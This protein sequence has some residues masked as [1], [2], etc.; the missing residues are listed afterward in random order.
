MSGYTRQQRIFIITWCLGVPLT[1]ASAIQWQAVS[2][3]LSG[4]AANGVHGTHPHAGHKR[5]C[6]VPGRFAMLIV[7]QALVIELEMRWSLEWNMVCCRGTST[8]STTLSTETNCF[9]TVRVLQ[10]QRWPVQKI[11]VCVAQWWR[12]AAQGQESITTL[13]QSLGMQHICSEACLIF[14][15]NQTDAC[16]FWTWLANSRDRLKFSVKHH[17]YTLN[18]RF[19]PDCAPWIT[20]IDKHALGE[21]LESW[22]SPDLD[23]SP[24]QNPSG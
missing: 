2:P 24:P 15:V 21:P 1:T 23:S 4:R 13:I 22:R 3:V 10:G 6:S 7:R 11:S 14:D 5:K 12:I 8:V 9:S 18:S 16:L 17:T 19:K 20:A